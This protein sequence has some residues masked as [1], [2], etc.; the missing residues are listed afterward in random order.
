MRELNATAEQLADWESG[1]MVQV[2][3]PTLSPAD[4]EFIM[5]GITDEVW[6]ERMIAPEDKDADV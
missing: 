5:T 2:A 4:R 6:Q 3:F 1:T